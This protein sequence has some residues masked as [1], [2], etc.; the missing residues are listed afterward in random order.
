MK[1]NMILPLFKILASHFFSFGTF[2]E[3]FK[4][5]V[6]GILKNI[7]V[8]VLIL[9]F[10]VVAGGMYIAVMNS[11]G[12]GLV[13]SGDIEKMPVMIVFAAFC[14]VLF[15]GFISAATNYYT[16]CGEEQFLAMPLTPK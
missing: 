5:G 3:G 8:I 7:L 14:L 2:F 1:Q 16:G 12:N 15:F 6:K 9:Y 10:I 11:V 13:N 4:K